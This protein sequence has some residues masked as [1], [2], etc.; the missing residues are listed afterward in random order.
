MLVL[1]RKNISQSECARKM[2]FGRANINNW[3]KL[4]AKVTVDALIWMLNE[5]P[6]IDARWL[7]TGRTLYSS[8]ENS[9]PSVVNDYVEE[10]SKDKIIMIQDKYILEL[11]TKIKL[12]TE[13]NRQ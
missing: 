10:K 5:Y 11:E 8:H 4:K 6:E 2:G 9:L 3:A 1:E 13:N 7:L 12:L